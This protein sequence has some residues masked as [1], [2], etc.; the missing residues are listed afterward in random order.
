LT[1]AVSNPSILKF[2][3]GLASARVKGKSRS[4]G[5]LSYSF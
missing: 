5:I 2:A 3:L 4:V 1:R